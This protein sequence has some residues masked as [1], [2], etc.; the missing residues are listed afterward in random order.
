MA[1]RYFKLSDDVHWPGRWELGAPLDG[2]GQ[3]VWTW[4]AG[5]ARV[6]LTPEDVARLEAAFPLG[7]VGRGLPMV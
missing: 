3:K 4:L 7:P 2:R 6:R 5:A 1:R